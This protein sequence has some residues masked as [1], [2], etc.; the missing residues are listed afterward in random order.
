[1]SSRRWSPF[2]W[3]AGAVAIGAV[4]WVGWT[5]ASGNTASVPGLDPLLKVLA[6]SPERGAAP[7]RKGPPSGPPPAVT[8]SR[9]ATQVVV[10]W[11]EYT[12][13]FEAIETVEVRARIAGYLE[14]VHFKDGQTV[15]RGDL[16]YTIDARPFER[17]LDQARAEVAQAQTKLENS[18]RDVDRGRPLVD[19]KIMSE[20]V[21]DDRANVQREAEAALKVAQAK[22]RTAEL[23]LSFTRLTA[24]ISGRISR[25]IVTAGN[26]LS[27][28][29]NAQPTLLT[30]IV[31]QN[32]IHVYFDVSEAAAIKYR[33]MALSGVKAV[34]GETGAEVQLALPDEKGFPHRATVDFSDNR[35]DQ[36]TGTLRLRAVVD[37]S[38]GL[39]AAGIFARV[40]VA[41]SAPATAMLLP[42]E[43]FGTDQ[44]AKFV[45]VVA[46]DGT[47][48]RRVVAQGPIVNGLRIVRSG[49]KPEDWVVIRGL[50][51][52]RPGQKVTPTREVLKVTD[53]AAPARAM[54]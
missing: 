51:R 41:G 11:D 36:N 25:S 7:A 50:Q 38:K 12:G 48:Q 19:R 33:R 16:L 34:A 39:F 5:A 47:V 35:L 21:F 43:A 13:R 4:A 49:I 1:M 20:K 2:R 27:G 24:P 8:V 37:N 31:A 23:D 52:A 14:A 22:V 6:L 46:E 3:L 32:P 40:R 18:A 29:G 45:L 44:A 26:Y 17:T 54:P 15:G 53:A 10:E 30:T 42:D 28:G 9:P